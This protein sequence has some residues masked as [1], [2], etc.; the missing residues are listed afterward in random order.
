M[1]VG[2]LTEVPIEVSLEVTSRF[3]LGLEVTARPVYGFFF[4][5]PPN[6]L[7]PSSPNIAAVWNTS[8]GLLSVYYLISGA[9]YSLEAPVATKHETLIDGVNI[10]WL[11]NLP[12]QAASVTIAGAN[13]QLVMS[14]AQPGHSGYLSIYQDNIGGRTIFAPGNSLFTPGSGGNANQFIIGSSPGAR[15]TFSW[16]YD[17]TSFHWARQAEPG[18]F[19]LSGTTVGAAMIELLGPSGTRAKI[20][21]GRTW[22]ARIQ[23]VGRSPA[24]DHK[25]FE[26]RCIIENTLG[27]VFLVA[28]VQ[29][30]VADIFTGGAAA[31]ALTV[32]ADNANDSLRVQV[33]TDAFDTGTNWACLIDFV[34]VAL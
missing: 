26:R 21:P 27:A 11:A 13:R 31:W 12:V 23:V 24:A 5:N 22:V 1:A 29:T 6:P 16:F 14:G 17:G 30:P 15:E 18:S 8:S 19:R 28:P 9:S 32:S 33:A 2:R 4:D 20:S 10:N 25:A 3:S 34:E 7:L